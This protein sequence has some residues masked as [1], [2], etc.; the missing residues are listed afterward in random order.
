MSVFATESGV[1]L[2]AQIDDTAIA[3]TALI[4]S[5]IAEAHEAV[6]ADLDDSVDQENPPDALVQ[7]ETLMA[8]SV[9]MRA[10]ASRD[11]VE[12]VELQI[13]GQRIGAGQRFASLMTVARQFEKEA[14]RALGSFAV[15][16]AALPPGELTATTEVLGA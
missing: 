4:E 12:Q 16:P 10:L 5:C 8:V 14:A 3:S 15:K 6:L 11:A 1:R 13:G 9:L 7:G 2:A